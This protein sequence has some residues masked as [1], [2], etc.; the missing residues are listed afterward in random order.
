MQTHKKS[1]QTYHQLRIKYHLAAGA[2]AQRQGLTTFLPIQKVLEKSFFPE[3][4]VSY[5]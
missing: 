3:V 5:H 1:W 4:R 2:M